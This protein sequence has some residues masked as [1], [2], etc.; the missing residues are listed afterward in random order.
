V[1]KETKQENPLIKLYIIVLFFC[2]IGLWFAIQPHPKQKISIDVELE[3]RVVDS[4]V[5]GGVTQEDILSQYVR[6]RT[7]SRAQWNEF[8]KK[9][10]L[11]EDKKAENFE[12]PFRAIARSME[13]GLSKTENPDG[14]IAY[15]FFV[16]DR[17]YS[18][19][20]FV[21]SPKKNSIQ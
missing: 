6:E 4:L 13:V 5:A 18:N 12:I 7:T 20:T 14:S 8:Y 17:H 1:P 19:I 3:R 9:I 10:R 11:K 21:N 2:G 16:P 15:K